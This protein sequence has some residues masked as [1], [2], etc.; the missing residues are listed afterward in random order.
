MKWTTIAR[1]C[2][3]CFSLP[4]KAEIWTNKKDTKEKQINDY[5]W[6]FACV[7]VFDHLSYTYSI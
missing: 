5:E 1:T 4:T 7:Y 3:R 2:V 6:V